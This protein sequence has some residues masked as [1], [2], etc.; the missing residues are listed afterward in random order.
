[1]RHDMILDLESTAN[2]EEYT[3]LSARANPLD[4]SLAQRTY[5]C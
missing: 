5:T 1:M 4:T 2:R 3:Y